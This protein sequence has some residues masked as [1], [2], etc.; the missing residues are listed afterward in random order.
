[1]PAARPIHA[2]RAPRRPG[3]LAALAG[4]TAFGA[5]VAAACGDAAPR[6]GFEDAGPEPPAE[7]A[8]V[9]VPTST[10][11]APRVDAS[12]RPVGDAAEDD[13]GACART[14]PSNRCGLVSQCGCLPSETCDVFDFQEGGVGCVGYGTAAL[15]HP[16]TSTA[17]CAKG[18]ACVLGVCKPFCSTPGAACDGADAGACQQIR[19]TDG[20]PVP[21]LTVCRVRCELRT[22][23]GCGGTNAAGT[24]TCI[25]D[26]EGGTD[27]TQGG[28]IAEK[29]ACSE[30][31]LCAP[32][33]A[34]VSLSTGADECRRWCRVGTTDC[35]VGRTCS[36][37][38]QG[39]VFVDG[40]EHGV[41]P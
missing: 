40:V 5:F 32:G 15:G 14:P 25:P 28:A 35:G 38:T 37:F 29:Q 39:K 34:C 20:T 11:T 4:V 7:D 6:V 26:G 13:A 8:A 30:A 9:P 21:N 18:L 12:P 31:R 19:F 16:C 23:L 41:C 3:A 33:L 1:M 36:G 22:G 2:S 17:G 10:A 24:G 27:C